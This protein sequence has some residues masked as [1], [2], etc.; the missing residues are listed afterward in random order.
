ML[1]RERNRIGNRAVRTF[2][3]CCNIHNGIRSKGERSGG[4][5]TKS[6]HRR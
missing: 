6:I 4:E 1:K 3:Y 2:L 5:S